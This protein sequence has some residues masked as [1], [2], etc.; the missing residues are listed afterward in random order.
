MCIDYYALNAITIR[1][2]YPLSCIDVI[3]NCLAKAKYFSTLNLNMTY[4]Q[5]QLD[6]GS[7]EYI[8]FTCK[9]GHY[10]FKVMTF[11][12]INA[13]S[14]FQYMITDYLRNIVKTTL[15]LQQ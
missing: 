15:Q 2:E 1:N 13:P 12:F 9:E 5:V 4:H 11:R 14:M 7:K 3:F 6:D 10:Q 8:V